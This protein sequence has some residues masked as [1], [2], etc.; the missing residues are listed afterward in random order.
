MASSNASRGKGRAALLASAPNRTELITVPAC[1]E[2]A[3]MSKPMKRFERS[4]AAARI[5]FVLARPS[6]IADFSEIA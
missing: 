2:A 3:S 5:R 4:L 1:S 6:P